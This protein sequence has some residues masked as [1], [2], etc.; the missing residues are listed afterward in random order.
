MIH[1]CRDRPVILIVGRHTEPVA[2][3]HWIDVRMS[4]RRRHAVKVS[5]QR[6]AQTHRNDV[7]RKGDALP[8]RGRARRPRIIQRDPLPGAVIESGKISLTHLHGRHSGADRRPLPETEILPSGKNEGPVTP[9]VQ[10]RQPHGASQR[11][12]KLIADQLRRLLIEILPAARHTKAVIPHR[13]KNGPVD[14]VAAAFRG[15]NG[16]R[17]PVVLRRRNAGFHP[18]FVDGVDARRPRC[19]LPQITLIQRGAVLN[20]LHRA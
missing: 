19:Q 17:R 12:A 13:V 11:S 2:G 10:L 6:T 5:C 3:H 7:V 14:L 1:S 20:V 9:V 18:K 8:G 16:A 4:G 15:H